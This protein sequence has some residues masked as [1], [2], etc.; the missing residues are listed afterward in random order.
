M[1]AAFTFAK[2]RTLEMLFAKDQ[3]KDSFS[4][5]FFEVQKIAYL[6]K[7]QAEIL[8]IFSKKKLWS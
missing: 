4:F 6:A 8:T 1:Y 2:Q 5:S 3:H 7:N